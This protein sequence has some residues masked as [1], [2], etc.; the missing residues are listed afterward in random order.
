M[1]RVLDSDS[2]EYFIEVEKSNED[3]HGQITNNNTENK[4]T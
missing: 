4:K 3:E 1:K 2:R